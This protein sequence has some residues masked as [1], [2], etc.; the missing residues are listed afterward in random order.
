MKCPQTGGQPS[1]DR[2]NV[3]RKHFF[4][5]SDRLSTGCRPVVDQLWTGRQLVFDRLNPRSL[6]PLLGGSAGAVER[7]REK[8]LCAQHGRSEPEAFRILTKQ[9]KCSSTQDSECI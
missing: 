7:E 5:V 4:V 8:E 6:N 2:S 9:L 3:E 1:T